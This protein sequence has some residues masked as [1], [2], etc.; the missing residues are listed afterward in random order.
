[1]GTCCP[2]GTGTRTSGGAAPSPEDSTDAR[3]GMA[4]VATTRLPD[5]R[6][7]IIGLGLIGG[8]VARA[9]AARDAGAWHVVAWSRSREG[10]RAALADGVI[11]AVAP[12][13][14]D[15]I[16]DAELVL[17]AASPLANLDLLRRLGPQAVQSGA[18][19]TDVTSAQARLAATADDV[20][21]LRYIGGHPMAGAE[22]RGYDAARADLFLDRPWIVLPGRDAAEE[23]IARVE[24]LGRACGGRIVRM[25]PQV[26]DHLVAAVSHLP[27]AVAAALAETVIGDAAWSDAERLAAGGWRDATRVARGDADLATGI[28]ALNR[29]E[30]VAWLDRLSAVLSSW[31][32]DIAAI[33]DAP[34]DHGL[35]VVRARFERVRRSLTDVP[36]T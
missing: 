36:R 24:T 5:M 4:L 3:R 12:S 21:G 10:P 17:L 26:H 33:P 7:A 31:R 8:S 35:D 29:D 9:L 20:P 22:A 13:A 30:L 19:V 28:A 23:D 15:A 34:D 6:L 16:A 11:D 18:V 1:M 27:L 2:T 32:A 14:G 25:A